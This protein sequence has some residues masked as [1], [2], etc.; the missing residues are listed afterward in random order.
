[1]KILLKLTVPENNC[2]GCPF[3][4][5]KVKE[6]EDRHDYETNKCRVFDC[7]ITNYQRCIACKSCEVD[8]D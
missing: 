5:R 8:N 7:K 3:L 1:M 6:G 4:Q 2:T